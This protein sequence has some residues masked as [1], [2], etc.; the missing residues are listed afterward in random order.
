MTYGV[1][2]A[3]FT[4]KTAENIRDSLIAAYRAATFKDELG[5][6]VP[7][8]GLTFTGRSTLGNFVAIHASELGT[9]WEA[10][11]AVYHGYDVDNCAT[12]EQ[13]EALCALTGVL[14]TGATKGTATCTINVDASFSASAGALVASVDGRPGELWRNQAAVT[15][16][17]GGDVT[18]VIFESDVT[19]ETP[20][21]AAGDLSVIAQTYPGWVSI[22]NPADA[23][24]GINQESLDSLRLKRNASLAA[25]GGS[26]LAGI[27]ADVSTLTGMLA[28]DGRDNRSDVF[29]EIPAHR[30]EIVVYGTTTGV[31]QQILDSAPAD[32]GSSYGSSSDTADDPL[33]GTQTIYFSEADEVDIYIEVEVAGTADADEVKAA[34]VAAYSPA[35]RQT[36]VVQYLRSVLFS[37]TGVTDVPS[38]EISTDDVTYSDAN[39]VP[40]F[41]Q[42]AVFDTSRIT[43]L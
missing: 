37:V 18:D 23:T 19:G 35:F 40:I 33:G 29:A 42:I 24:S 22:T 32:T 28:V 9:C 1:T 7:G 21:V 10:A 38:I 14:R 12:D 34:L 5:N 6:D 17:A 30:F 26:T 2:D 16:V 13:F 20:F 4:R 43:I 8:S 39:F 15:S 31:A 25:A 3:G 36:I 11:E 41:G 27:V